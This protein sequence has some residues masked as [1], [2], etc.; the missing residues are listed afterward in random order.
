[1]AYPSFFE[2]IKPELEKRWD[3]NIMQ[4]T[5]GKTYLG[6]RI[7]MDPL[8]YGFTVWDDEKTGVLSKFNNQFK[9]KV[10]TQDKSL[11]F[12]EDKYKRPNDFNKLTKDVL[13][14]PFQYIEQIPTWQK[15]AN[16]TDESVIGRFENTPVYANSS[17]QELSITL[18]YYAENSRNSH[19]EPAEEYDNFDQFG[20][21]A[22]WTL[23]AVE[24]FKVQLQSL[25]FP[26]YDGTYAPP[27]KVLLNLGNIYVDFP[28]VIKSISIEEPGPIEMFSFRGMMKKITVE[29]RSAYPQWQAL[30]AVQIWSSNTG[31]VFGRQDFVEPTA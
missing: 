27:I 16:W 2:G 3:T 1:M 11:Y 21:A 14:I 19:V 12:R 13:G 5:P 28:V 17:G 25:V 31:A 10:V 23:E 29:M 30:S 9:Q 7:G 24:R 22:D 20:S 15:S 8:R 6:N 4:Y 18:I 26:Q